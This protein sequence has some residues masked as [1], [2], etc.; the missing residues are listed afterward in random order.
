MKNLRFSTLPLLLAG[1][2]LCGASS[3]QIALAQPEAPAKTDAPAQ[4]KK[5]RADKPKGDK[6]RGDKPRGKNLSPRMVK[7]IEEAMGKPL[8][9]E[10]KAQLTDALHAREAAVQAANDAF[11]AAFAQTTGLTP[12]QAKEIDKPA[13]GGPKPPTTPKVEGETN[14]DALTDKGAAGG[15]PVTPKNQ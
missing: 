8:T 11:Y 12:E 15:T 13:R 9:P 3:P 4:P 5:P 6:P 1:I 10:M 2:A 14:M 7:G